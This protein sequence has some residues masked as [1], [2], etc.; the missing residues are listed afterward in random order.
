MGE[1]IYVP[2]IKKH[3]EDK[4]LPPIARATLIMDGYGPHCAEETSELFRKNHIDLL[5]LP[6]H[7]SHGFQ[8][9]DLCTFHSMKAR[10]NCM[11]TGFVKGT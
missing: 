4:K 3:R 8:P 9:L 2:F 7:S 5:I 1:K 10:I 11:Q 6:V